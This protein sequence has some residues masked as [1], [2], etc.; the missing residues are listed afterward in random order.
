M[1]KS[2]VAVLVALMV[3]ALG[4]VGHADGSARAER[5]ER[6][7]AAS[8]CSV[9]WEIHPR[10]CLAILATVPGAVIYEDGTGTLEIDGAAYVVGPCDGG[11]VVTPRGVPNEC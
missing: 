3:G 11:V 7:G 10:D 8:V 9:V 1:R 6:V 4:M 5:A 2:I